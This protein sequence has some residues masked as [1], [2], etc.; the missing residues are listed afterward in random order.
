VAGA[1]QQGLVGHGFFLQ[2]ALQGALGQ[3]FGV[4]A[5]AWSPDDGKVVSLDHGCGA[6]SETD[7]PQ[8]ATDWPAPDPLIDELSIDVEAAPEPAAAEEP[9]AEAPAAAEPAAEA[10][11]DEPAEETTPAP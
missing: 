9:A 8:H 3:V 4:C 10:S 1:V 6:H 11:A 7:V 5:N 2:P